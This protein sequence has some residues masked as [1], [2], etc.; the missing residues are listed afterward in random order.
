MTEPQTPGGADLARQMLR[1]A[2]ADAR[3]RPTGPAKRK[4]V[5]RRAERGNGRDPLRF[6]GILEHLADTYGWRRPSA[7]GLITARWP[8]LMP[9][10]AEH[11]APE[12]YDTDTRTLYLRPATTAAA[13]KLRWEAAGI[14]TALNEAVGDGTVHA[15][16]VLPPG[17]ITPAGNAAAADPGPAERPE[18]PAPVRTRDDAA[19]GFHQTLAAINRTPPA[20]QK[21]RLQRE[22]GTGE[23]AHLREPAERFTDAQVALETAE[24]QSGGNDP[25][26]VRQAAIRIARAQKAGQTP[27]IPTAFQRTA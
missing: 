11:A 13:T 4:P 18:E 12:R 21:P 19:P 2:Q 8:Q 1:R 15:V 10:L 27:A 26:A 20:G 24:A 7:A 5:R 17:P 23:Y 25:D 3:T 6:D 16:K 22:W 14:T 9:H